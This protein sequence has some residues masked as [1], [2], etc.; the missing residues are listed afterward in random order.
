MQGDLRTSSARGLECVTEKRTPASRLRRPS[1]RQRTV[2]AEISPYLSSVRSVLQADT[3]EASARTAFDASK[4]LTGATVGSFALF[5]DDGAENEVL[6]LDAGG[7]PCKPG[8]ELPTPIGGLRF[9]SYEL[10]RVAHDNG[11]MNS[12]ERSSCQAATLT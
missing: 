2:A 5:S 9:E 3:F 10:R 12:E 1:R 11:F 7:W 6:F 4:R 8:P